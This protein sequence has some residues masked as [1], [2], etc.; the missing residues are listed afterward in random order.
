MSS[1]SRFEWSG[2]VGIVTEKRRIRIDGRG[3]GVRTRGCLMADGPE[4]RLNE[5]LSFGNAH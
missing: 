5:S 1:V 3:K 2:G 4:S